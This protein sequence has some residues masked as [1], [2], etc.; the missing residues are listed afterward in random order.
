MIE[1]LK[2]LCNFVEK[3][4]GTV[5][6]GNDQFAPIIGYEDLL[7]GN[8]TVKRVYYVEGLNNNL[9]SIG[10]LCDVDLEVSFRKS[11]C[12]VRDLQEPTTL[13]TNVNAE[14]N[15]TDQA[16]DA[17]FQPYEFFNPLCTPIQKVTESSSRNID[18]SNMRTFYQPHNSEYRW[19]KNHPL[20]QIHGNPSKPVQTRRQ[21]ATDPEI[22]MFALTVS[23]A[24]STNIKKVMA[25]HAWIKAMQ[26]ELL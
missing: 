5:R 15:N 1:N 9:F 23:T 13:T 10:Q 3:Y 20:E 21:L 22:C 16:A 17:Q 12:F 2:L 24:Y 8:T 4:L 19:A 25:D 11:T 26:E 14:E 18:N 6:F 7:Q